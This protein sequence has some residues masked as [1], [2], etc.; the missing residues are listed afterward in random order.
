MIQQTT[1]EGIDYVALAQRQTRAEFMA[2]C[3]NS[4]LFSA[5]A[6]TRPRGPQPTVC[7]TSYPEIQRFLAGGPPPALRI[8][9]PTVFPVVK[10]TTSYASMI[11]IGRT[12]NHDVTIADVEVSKFHALIREARGGLELLDA[13]SSNGTWVME[14][15]LKPREAYLLQSGDT[16]RFGR[17]RFIYCD[18][19]ACWDRLRR[20]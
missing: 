2:K 16:L 14:R 6:L 15:R 19:G 5:D 20:D 9:S 10:V 17:L 8:E 3:R 4:F 13:G 18:A 11:T 12:S 1:V 7:G